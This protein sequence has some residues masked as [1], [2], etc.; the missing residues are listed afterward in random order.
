MLV[1]YKNVYQPPGNDGYR[2]WF[3]NKDDIELIIWFSMAGEIRGFQICYEH[4]S[5]AFTWHQ[6][7]GFSHSGIHSGGGMLGTAS[8]I[9]SGSIPG[10]TDELAA[11]F[12]E[13]AE[14]LE[15]GLLRHVQNKMNEFA[16]RA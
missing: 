14:G 6:D 16:R 12:V 7:Y 9:L 10:S 11:R 13:T 1:E 2:R 5:R 15:T 8:P 4:D 3:S